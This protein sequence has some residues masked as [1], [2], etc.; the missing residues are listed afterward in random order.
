MGSRAPADR[1][2]AMRGIEDPQDSLFNF[3]SLEERVPTCREV[4]TMVSCTL[5][6]LPA[7]LSQPSAR[8]GRPSIPPA[9]WLRASLLQILY[10]VRSEGLLVEQVDRNL[11][12]RGFV[13]LS[14][15]ESMWNHSAF[16]KNRERI[17]AVELAGAL[18]GWRLVILVADKGYNV[19][20]NTK[21]FGGSALDRWTTRHPVYAVRQRKRN[22][23]QEIFGWPRAVD[24]IR[25][26]KF[27][28]VEPIAPLLHPPHRRLQLGG[29]ASPYPYCR[30]RQIGGSAPVR[31]A[32]QAP[33]PP[34]LHGEIRPG[35]GN[36][37]RRTTGRK[38][39]G[40]H[41]M[42]RRRTHGW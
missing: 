32:P 22:R 38:G 33:L 6:E 2:D 29:P 42:A 12:L 8:G 14:I 7:T 15:E 23:V 39:E 13:G 21:R 18:L 26:V 9:Q 36:S 25:Q 5:S 40:S 17:L 11:L 27:R 20:Q 4:R 1:T 3:I 41:R 37:P 35:E 10:A 19:A 28:E 24:L 30:P 16:S 31:P 34:C